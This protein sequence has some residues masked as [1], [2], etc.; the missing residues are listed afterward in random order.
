MAWITQIIIGTVPSTF[1]S[2]LIG[3]FTHH[4]LLTKVEETI[5][6]FFRNKLV[7]ERHRAFWTVDFLLKAL[8]AVKVP[9]AVAVHLLWII[10]CEAFSTFFLLFYSGVDNNPAFRWANSTLADEPKWALADIAYW[11]RPWRASFFGYQAA[12]A[13]CSVALTAVE[14][15]FTI[16]LS[17]DGQGSSILNLSTTRTTPVFTRTLL[18]V[19][20]WLTAT[21]V[22][23][24]VRFQVIDA[25]FGW[26]SLD[27]FCDWL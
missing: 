27:H 9:T 2:R 5:Y 7:A 22:I 4:A 25:A 19:S 11:A 14:V 21:E 1:L 17:A 24:S 12:L 13:D 10:P 26:A 8:S 20:K 23:H 3:L 16:A 6:C 15:G 18:T